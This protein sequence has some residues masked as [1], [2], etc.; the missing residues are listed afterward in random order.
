M[1][2]IT[3]LWTLA[4]GFSKGNAEIVVF[5]ANSHLK[6][7]RGACCHLKY[8]RGRVFWC[9]IFQMEREKNVHKEKWQKRR[10]I[11]QV[12]CLRSGGDWY[13]TR[14]I[15]LTLWNF[16]MKILLTLWNIIGEFRHAGKK[17]ATKSAIQEN[18]IKLKRKTIL[19]FSKGKDSICRWFSVKNN[20]FGSY[21]TDLGT[22]G[23][24][25]PRFGYWK[26]P[27]YQ[28]NKKNNPEKLS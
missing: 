4:C 1:W 18:L 19:T 26:R 6:F 11:F 9:M 22:C 5:S 13:I 21:S 12:I 15:S 25:I 28:K 14:E 7:H 23:A 17:A 3:W 8:H 2:K 20:R 24:Q 10:K 16:T 27:S